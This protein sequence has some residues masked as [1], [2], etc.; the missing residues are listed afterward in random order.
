M[1]QRI[2]VIAGNQQSGMQHSSLR[3]VQT[4]LHCIDPPACASS[5]S[6][7][8]SVFKVCLLSSTVALAAMEGMQRVIQ[9]F[10]LVRT[11]PTGAP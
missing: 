8:H 11:R 4:P 7:S 1:L 2:A 10:W 3:C 5:P 9:Q 6:M